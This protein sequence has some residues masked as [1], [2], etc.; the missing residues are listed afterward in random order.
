MFVMTICIRY[1]CYGYIELMSARVEVRRKGADGYI[2]SGHLPE[3]M[4]EAADQV[5]LYT[6]VASRMCLM[7]EC[8]TDL[9]VFSRAEAG[10]NWLP[11][12]QPSI[13]E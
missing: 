8:E 1:D 4:A 9:E 13:A 2:I 10:D 3:D 12:R 6:G 11:Y 5:R 7:A